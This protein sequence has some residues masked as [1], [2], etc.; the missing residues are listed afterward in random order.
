MSRLF[1]RRP[2]PT[3]A[4]L[5]AVFSGFHPPPWLRGEG[6][7][8]V[9]VK[10]GDYN[11][12]RLVLDRNEA[13]ALHYELEDRGV[14]AQGCEAVDVQNAH[15]ELQDALGLRRVDPESVASGQLPWSAEPRGPGLDLVLLRTTFLRAA[16]MVVSTPWSRSGRTKN[17]TDLIYEDL[18]LRRPQLKPMFTDHVLQRHKL[19][20]MLGS[21]F[22]H[23]D[24][25]DWCAIHL[26]DL[27][28]LHAR[29]GVTPEM[30]G[31]VKD[32]VLSV[33]GQ[34]M[35]GNGWNVLCHRQWADALDMI[36]EG[37]LM[38][39]SNLSSQF[40]TANANWKERYWVHG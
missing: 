23:L 19:G 2:K 30:Y 18:F 24:D 28:Q 5:P 9:V 6:L 13:K 34:A 16:E 12:V 21:L 14:N 32:A 40:L 10:H 27:G 11:F 25:A 35:A 37:M 20:K 7:A 8:Y 4:Q 17:V 36:A 39:Y 33:F 3:E 1:S 31:W 22:I 38:G 26:S 15:W 29:A